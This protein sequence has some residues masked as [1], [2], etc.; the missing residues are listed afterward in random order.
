MDG[1]A[2]AMIDAADLK[3]WGIVKIADFKYLQKQIAVLVS[4]QLYPINSA[5]LMNEGQKPAPTTY[6]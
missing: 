1:T 5:I 6:V 3:R 4:G 2:L